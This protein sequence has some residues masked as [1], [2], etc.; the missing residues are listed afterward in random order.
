MSQVPARVAKRIADGLRTFHPILEAA[1]SR[2]VNESDTVTVV[3]DMLQAVFGYD[4]YAEITSEHAIRGTYCDLAIK[5]DGTIILLVEVKAIG[6]E[7]KDQHVKQAVDYATNQ[8]VEWVALTNGQIWRLYSVS[9]GKPVNFDLL[10]ELDIL[11]LDARNA[12][13]IASLF[14]ISREGWKKS[15][16]D[17]Y[18]TQR[19]AVNRYTVAAAVLDDDCVQMIRRQLRRIAPST[20]IDVDDIR[21]ILNSDVLKRE[22][23]DGERA[24]AARR[25][26]ARSA[27][28]A[29]REV[30]PTSQS[31]EQTEPTTPPDGST[32]DAAATGQA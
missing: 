25:L 16:I 18:R 26:V 23:I 32:P 12:D 5:V 19:Q 10:L 4:K 30:H 15:T 1:R 2:D 7:L 28:R 31:Q 17:E 3:T 14:L 22:S 6:L 24:D 29:L 27:R 13:D 20:R 8:G 9:F 21:R 11:Q